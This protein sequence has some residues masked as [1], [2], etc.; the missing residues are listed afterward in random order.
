MEEVSVI[1]GEWD[2]IIRITAKDMDQIG[3]TIIQD[4]RKESG[5]QKTITCISFWTYRGK[6]P[7]QLLLPDKS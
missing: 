6:N 5:I 4:L 7:F 1:T 3:E 2:F